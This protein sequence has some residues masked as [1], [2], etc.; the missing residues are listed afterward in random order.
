MPRILYNEGRVVGYSAYEEYVRQALQQ[1]PDS[2]PATEKE[3]LASTISI[4]SSM[5]LHIQPDAENSLTRDFKLPETSRLFAANTIIGSF[6]EGVGHDSA[7]SPWCDYVESYG[8]LITNTTASHPTTDATTYP[9]T[10]DSDE[11]KQKID[12]QIKQYLKIKDGVVIKE[13]TW[14]AS[15]KTPPAEVL[16]S[17]NNNPPVVRLSFESKI[18]T[19]FYILLS[20]FTDKAVI[21]GVTNIENQTE[22]L[23]PQNG[24]FLGPAVFPWANKIIFTLSSRQDEI[25]KS[26]T[27]GDIKAGIGI[28]IDKNN[29]GSI[30]INNSAPNWSSAKYNRVYNADLY[31]D[32]YYSIH[33]FNGWTT[34]MRN[35]YESKLGGVYGGL[36]YILKGY[37][38]F[39]IYINTSYDDSGDLI[40]FGIKLANDLSYNV[41]SNIDKDGNVQEYTNTFIDVYGRLMNHNIVN[42]AGFKSGDIPIVTDEPNVKKGIG[43]KLLHARSLYDEKR[44][45]NSNT[46]T[47]SDK[48]AKNNIYYEYQSV[49]MAIQFK[50][51]G[52]SSKT[53]YQIESSK[54]SKFLENAA[55]S[56]SYTYSSV[57]GSNVLNIMSVSWSGD[58]AYNAD[59]YNEDEIN[60]TYS[61]GDK[62]TGLFGSYSNSTK[63]ELH[64]WDYSSGK[65]YGSS[66]EV[67]YGIKL[68]D[69]DLINESK[70]VYDDYINSG[71]TEN[72]ENTFY[73]KI[74]CGGN[75]SEGEI[76]KIGDILLIMYSIS[77]GYNNQLYLGNSYSSKYTTVAG[78]Q[79]NTASVRVITTGAN[80]TVNFNITKQ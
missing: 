12:N 20:G 30:T 76:L 5:L 17:T 19:D 9:S 72:A 42:L 3:W 53:K 6:F 78:D 44:M 31:T 25:I 13:G 38:D 54:I 59:N 11:Y 70:A 63:N 8:N 65:L 56:S 58:S 60:H 51:Y 48:D 49:L 67:S 61:V 10:E 47:S 62:A 75:A 4:G 21:K 26:N 43:I 1:D 68:V 27:L 55:S 39:P 41:K 79:P 32:G 33:C 37:H 52:S 45:N 34:G 23:S 73:N 69:A 2:T 14:T 50:D 28:N 7:D 66:W 77:D 16:T 80:I 64:G 24:D 46:I 40:S 57:Y 35:L 29:D 22:T 71:S 18:D 15:A 74:I 36:H